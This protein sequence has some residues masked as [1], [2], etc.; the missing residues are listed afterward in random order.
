MSI[1]PAPIQRYMPSAGPN[2]PWFWIPQLPP[3]NF[4]SSYQRMPA[5]LP[6]GASASTVCTQVS[7]W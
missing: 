7:A 4:L 2:V 5:R 6:L 3:V 1:A